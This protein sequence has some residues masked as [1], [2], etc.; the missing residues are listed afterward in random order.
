VDW[1]ARTFD[2]GPADR[3][4]LTSG[5]AHDPALRDILVPL[6]LGA[7]LD[8][9]AAEAMATPEQLAAW[10]GSRGTTVLHLTPPTARFLSGLPDGCLPA[11]R[12]AFFGGDAL[13][14]KEVATLRRLAPNAAI[15]NFYGATETPQAQA[16]HAIDELPEL[17]M[18]P[19]GRGIEGS[20]LLVLRDDTPAGVGELGEIVVRGPYLA[21]G[22]LTGETTGF[23]DDPHGALR[24]RTGDLGRY[25]ADGTVSFAGRGDR[26]V[27]VRGHRVDLA[28]VEALLREHRA[29]TGAFTEIRIDAAG[30]RTPVAWVT[31]GAPVDTS[32]LRE[33]LRTRLPS[34]V[35]PATI[36]V[37]EAFPLTANGKVDVLKLRSS[38]VTQP[39][40]AA[41]Q[42]AA[43]GTERRID[44]IW[45]TLLNTD[46]IGRQDTFFDLGGHSLLLIRLQTLIGEEFEVGMPVV[47]LFRH[48][49]IASLARAVDGRLDP[50]TGPS[51]DA[52]EQSARRARRLAER[53]RTNRPRADT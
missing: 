38:A 26:Q 8:V 51:D 25:R 17:A 52:R 27:K 2:V 7:Q 36:T 46:H 31:C 45:R 6:S 18:S 9:P 13:T 5:L 33:H 30:E 3:F 4:A 43:T 1:Y 41:S 10:L 39:R 47:D 40:G 24:Y 32:E 42:P 37:V 49:T 28:E 20:Q 11:L 44:A 19:L 48:P 29:V 14:G 34:A 53:R 21:D 50:A 22:Y 35:V 15:V 12:Y 23:T 16:W